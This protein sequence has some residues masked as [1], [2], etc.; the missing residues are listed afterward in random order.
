MKNA[1]TRKGF[2][3]AMA[4]AGA[5]GCTTF[6]FAQRKRWYRGMLH[7]HSLWSDGRALPEQTFASYK[8]AGYDFVSL[9]DHNR[10]QDVQDRWIPVGTGKETGWPPRTIHPACFEAYMKRF[11]KT[12]DVRE[13]NGKKEARLLTY[14]ELKNMFDSPGEFLVVPGVE[15]TTNTGTGAAAR[16]MHMNVIGVDAVI[17]RSRKSGLIENLKNHTVVSAMQETYEMYEKLR[18]ERGV[19]K[20]LYILDHPHWPYC[21]VLAKDMIG[22]SSIGGFEICN[23]GSWGEAPREYPD[24]LFADNLWDAT[25]VKRISSGQG[26]LYAFAT[27]DT[28]FY[29][30][31]GFPPPSA[32]K[33]GYIM[34]RA[35]ELSQDSLFD[36]IERGD[37]YASSELDLDDVSFDAETGTLSVSATPKTLESLKISFIAS[38]K[39]ASPEP[40]S[41]IDVPAKKGGPSSPRKIPLYG[42]DVG[43]TVKLVEGA[44]GQRLQ[45]SYTLKPDDLY[46]RARVESDVPS[47]FRKPGYFHVRVHTAWTQPYTACKRG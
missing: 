20:A 3:G 40:V 42:K 13:K 33:D 23:T 10:F 32:F 25:L 26:M 37:F 36:A 6:P 41:Y 12:A 2:I 16:A 38:K 28:H 35:E 39:G 45:A 34:V 47:R 22:A 24:Y 5:A 18:A 19:K 30:A 44:P 43:A 8:D 1:M 27:D 15:I 14:P 31:T 29:P 4:A 11:G 9:T 17:E 7:M 21:D 46:V